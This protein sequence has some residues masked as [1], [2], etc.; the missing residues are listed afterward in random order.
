MQQQAL[1][2]GHLSP[3]CE[4]ILSHL[5]AGGTLT[6]LSAVEQP[7]GT[8]CLAKRISEIERTGVEIDKTWETNGKKRWLRYSYH[9]AQLRLL[10]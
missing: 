9:L 6:A 7:F 5:I 10:A 4:T 8:T 2:L 3:Q 1:N